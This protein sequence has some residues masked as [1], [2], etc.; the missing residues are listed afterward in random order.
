MRER[1]F[2]LLEL[3]VVVTIM[4]IVYALVPQMFFSGVSGA[5]LRASSRDIAAGL[6]QARSIA[7]N[8]KRETAVTL[9]LE[10]RVFALAGNKRTIQ[11]PEKLDLKL[12]TAQSEI[13]NERQG[14]IRFFPDGS[15]TGGR[16]TVASGER[17][18]L[19]D[20]DWLTGKVSIQN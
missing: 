14:S 18:F 8:E 4:G 5:D 7:V 11:L 12:Y 1:G 10:K 2:T 16:V 13:V 6:R 15:S 19:V 3:L 20:V 9:D 17:K